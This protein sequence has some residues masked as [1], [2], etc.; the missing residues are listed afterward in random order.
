MMSD[1]GSLVQYGCGL[2]APQGWL[3]FDASPTL[4][5][6]RLPL[7]GGL[8][9]RLVGG[10]RFPGTVRFGDILRG[11]P[12]ASGS[13]RAVYCL[14]VLEHLALEDLRTALAETRR[15]LG[16][17]GVFRLVLPDLEAL[18]AEYS[19]ASDPRA[20]HRFRPRGFVGL[21][22]NWLG[23]SRHLWMWD[24]G[25][26]AAELAEAGF[27]DVRR[28]A[29]GDSSEPR[30]ADVEDRGRWDGQLGIECRR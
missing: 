27:R 5:L 15:L 12:V 13:C 3:N 4:R 30:F 11:L 14:H 17:G 22:R 8:R 9:R 23:N 19:A 21:L 1:D 26:L 16:E 10:P 20:A 18:V 24:Y 7:V 25:A 6:Q 29:F 28:A 2:C